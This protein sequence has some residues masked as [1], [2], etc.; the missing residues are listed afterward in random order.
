[1]KSS[2]DLQWQLLQG[3]LATSIFVN[4][5]DLVASVACPF[6][7]EAVLETLYH[8]LLDCPQLWHSLLPLVPSLSHCT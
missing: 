3:T 2:G 5:L 7:E 8:A 4:H 1:M 6:C